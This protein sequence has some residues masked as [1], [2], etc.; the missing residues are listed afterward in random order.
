[1]AKKT[2]TKA[3]SR[4][5]NKAIFAR[6]L[7]EF[8]DRQR[9]DIKKWRNA[10]NSAMDPES[11]KYY[12]LQDLYDNLRA[13]GHW[14]SQVELRKGSTLANTFNIIDKKS[15]QPDNDK[16]LIF[17]EQWFYDFMDEALDS[18][19]KGYTIFELTDFMRPVFEM[20][21][22]RN[23]ISAKRQI[24]TEVSNDA[25]IDYSGLI[26]DTIVEVGKPKQLGLMAD[27]C[28]LLIWKRNA[29]QSWAEY[30][31]KFGMPLITATSA[32]SN[33]QEIRRMEDM[34]RTLGEAAQAVMP[35]GTTIDIKSPTGGDNYQ[36]YDKQIDRINSEISKAVCG[37]TMVTD[38]GSSRSQSEVHERNLD[39]KITARDRR[40]IT[41]VVNDQL[42]PIL[43][44]N[45]FPLSPDTDRFEFEES[46]ELTLIDLLEVLKWMGDRYEIPTE[47]ISKTFNIPITAV[48]ERIIAA[49]NA[50]AP[51]L[52]PQQLAMFSQNF[53]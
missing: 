9:A 39:N 53:R 50:N 21:P 14:I 6:I 34:L 48:K 12:P 18:I 38:N 15:G 19:T 16:T 3:I 5:N 37:G 47:W 46:Y 23:V 1:M 24:T 43:A 51:A 41:F 42:I 44:R 31:E 49:V 30:S 11:P 20:I 2:L 10:V 25:G 45:G 4:P 33:P 29:Q 36:V 22:R 27:L 17:K 7:N 28:G 35:A 26:G 52:T 32:S 13:D 40:I 8:A